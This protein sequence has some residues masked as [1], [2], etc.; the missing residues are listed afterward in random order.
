MTKDANGNENCN[1]CTNTMYDP[2][3]VLTA[4][5]AK[6]AT[7]A[8]TAPIS[9]SPETVKTVRAIQSMSFP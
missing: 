9:R 6:G 3:D 1:N 5:Q 7:I 2:G 4:A 8:A